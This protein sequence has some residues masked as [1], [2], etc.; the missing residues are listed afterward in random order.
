VKLYLDENLSPRVVDLLR[1]GGCDAVSAYE[2]GNTQLDD[3]AQLAY[4]TREGRAMVTCD[5][6]DFAE[7]AAEAIRANTEH[8]GII[9]ISASFG[10]MSLARSCK[11]SRRSFA[12]PGGSSRD[13]SV[14]GT[15]CALRPTRGVPRSTRLPGDRCREGTARRLGL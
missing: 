5:V 10:R 11:A 8:A 2:V 6:A 7:L 12:L 14:R 4:A 15:P 9:L 13:S 1:A 3:R